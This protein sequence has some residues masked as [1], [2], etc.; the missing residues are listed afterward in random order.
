[1]TSNEPA[2][3]MR[4]FGAAFFRRDLEALAQVVTPDFE[5][6]FAIGQDSPDGRVY[7]GIDGVAR[8]FSERDRLLRDTRYEE[9]GTEFFGERGLMRYRVRGGFVDG[10]DFD[11][12]GV[13]LLEFRDGRLALK[14]VYWKAY[15]EL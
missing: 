10:D 14:D 4:R 11:L 8:G 15:R 12:R 9:V 6:R 5:W 1:M 3:I 7:R 2:D 13:E